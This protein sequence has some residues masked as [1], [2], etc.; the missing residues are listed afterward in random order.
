MVSRAKHK[1]SPTVDLGGNEWDTPV[2]S[3]RR[4]PIYAEENAAMS[5]ALKTPYNR[6]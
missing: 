2:P 6:A 1:T 5:A 4:T 3:V